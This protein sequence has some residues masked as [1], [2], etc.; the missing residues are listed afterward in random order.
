[1]LITPLHI[2]F[3]I[4]RTPDALVLSLSIL[5]NQSIRYDIHPNIFCLIIPMI[6]LIAGDILKFAMHVRPSLSNH[7]VLI[8]SLIAATPAGFVEIN[9]HVHPFTPPLDAGV[10]EELE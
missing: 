3:H 10:L 4:T 5:H 7:A 8:A 1:M 9:E 2:R 6:E